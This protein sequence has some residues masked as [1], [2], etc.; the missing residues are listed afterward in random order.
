VDTRFIYYYES[1]E[2]KRDEL[3]YLLGNLPR[4]IGI[5]DILIVILKQNYKKRF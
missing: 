1:I 5:E 4:K 3:F 2:N